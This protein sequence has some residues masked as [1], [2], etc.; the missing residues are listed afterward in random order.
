MDYAGN[1]TYINPPYE[2]VDEFRVNSSTFDARYG[3]GQGAV[4]FNM[5]SGTN[6]F[7]GD[8][9]EIL[10]NQLFDSD[11][12][13]PVRFSANGNPAPPIN[14]QNN[15]G[16]TLGGPVIIP[17]L[18]NGKN[19]TFFHYSSDWFSQNQAQTAI[20]T[21]PTPAM[22]SGDFSGFVDTTGTQIPIYDPQTGQPFPG[23]IIPQSRFSPLAVSVL[24]AIPNPDRAGLV[25]GLQSNKSPAVPSLAISQF[26]WA[27]TL[28]HN[29][30]SSQSIHFS[31][32][33]DRVV[34]P[35]I[36]VAPI[37]PLTNELQ[38]GV[39]NTN[40]GTGFLLNYVKTIS[41]NLVVTAGADWIG[42]LTDQNN[43]N[44]NVKFAGVVGG[45]TFPEVAF[46]GQNA[47]TSW[48]GPRRIQ[49]A[50]TADLP[51]MTAAS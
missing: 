20:G 17:K 25:S 38:S 36:S 37:V 35:T 8:V 13:F 11:G 40:L 18:Y 28:D 21:V 4:T 19:R 44:M 10:R 42:Y 39:N 27:Y 3:I 15:Y 51:K 49:D 33:R 24:P 43:A 12:F 31:Q 26:L 14:Q 22:K 2:S 6:Q 30:S 47:P 7:H 29:L 45:T 48:G 46:D 41:P 23:N 32:W 9:F 16:F 5:A 1:Q 50:A 34:S